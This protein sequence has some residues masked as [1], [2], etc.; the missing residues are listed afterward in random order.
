[1]KWITFKMLFLLRLNVNCFYD[2]FNYVRLKAFKS[3]NVHVNKNFVITY[4]T[5][6]VCTLITLSLRG[7]VKRC[8]PLVHKAIERTL[9]E[10]PQYWTIMRITSTLSG[11][12]VILALQIPLCVPRF[13]RAAND[14]CRA[15][16]TNM[17]SKVDVIPILQHVSCLINTLTK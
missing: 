5:F 13:A 7:S 16:I 8:L 11:I 4:I 17:P 10:W 3:N 9:H 2:P 12:L 14:I 1:M 15:K 6:H